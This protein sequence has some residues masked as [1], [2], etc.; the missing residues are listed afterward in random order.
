M[1]VVSAGERLVRNSALTCQHHRRTTGE[2]AGGDGHGRLRKPTAAHLTATGPYGTW[3]GSW[4]GKGR[5]R[6]QI[7]KRHTG[8]QTKPTDDRLCFRVTIKVIDKPSR[9][10][11]PEI[12]IDP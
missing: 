8:D 5:N 6:I 11:C 2:Q 1:W 4:D 7:V 9:N 3:D 12:L 10:S